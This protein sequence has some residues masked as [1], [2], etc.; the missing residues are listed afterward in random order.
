M[1]RL[2]SLCA[3]IVIGLFA[4]MSFSAALTESLKP[5]KAE[6]KSTGAMAFGPEGILFV[7]DSIGAAVYAL[8]TQD[9]TASAAAPIDIK[10]MNEKISAMLGTTRDEIL[11]NDLT[12]NPISKKIYLSVSRGR[13]PAA[14][15]VILRVDPKGKIEQFSLD[16][17]N[18]SKV[19]LMDAPEGT[20]ANRRLDAISDLAYVDGK[21][22]VAGLSNEEFASALRVF[23]F[24]FEKGTKGTSIEIWHTEHGRFETQS[25]IR[26][27]VPYQMKGEQY[28]VAAYG[29]TPLVKI[30][31]SSLKPGS[32]V[33]GMTIA[34][35]GGGSAPLSMITYS[36]DGHNYLLMSNSNRGVMKISADNLENYEPIATFSD[37]AGVPFETIYELQGIAQTPTN[38]QGVVYLDKVDDKTAAVLWRTSSGSMDLKTIALP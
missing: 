11:I 36:K 26:T 31:V 38:P 27:F 23:P 8:D 32:K 18:H 24:P 35:F 33:R 25:P 7:G 1:F 37:I 3:V 30:P 21:V 19:A 5:G 20:A 16:N 34:E 6:P 4:T 12:V 9:R 2:R 10:G 17:V 29:C 28:I 22:L 15:P 13:G 14:L